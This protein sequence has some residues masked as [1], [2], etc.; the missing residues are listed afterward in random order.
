ME[1]YHQPVLLEESVEGLNLQ[2]EGIYVDATFGGGGHARLILE[3]M[4]NSMLYAFDQDPDAAENAKGLNL[5]LVQA[6]F[7]YLKRYL[8]LYAVPA[9]DG[10]LADLGISSHQIDDAERGFSTRYDTALDMR[11]GQQGA[12]TAATILN[13]YSEPDL[14]QLLSRYGEVRNARTLAQAIGAARVNEPIK[15]AYEL[16]AILAR[17]APRGKENKYYAQVFQALRIAV[18]DEMGAL[19]DLLQQTAELLK[20]GGRMVVISYHSLED[21]MVKQFFAHGNFSG[22]AEKDFYGNSLATMRP[23]NRKP[24]TPSVT[25]IARNSRARSAKLRIGEKL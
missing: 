14:Q 16:K 12:L 3:K 21:R 5:T 6:N 8:R 23:V 9:I 7:R 15:T 4:Q 19:E 17:H 24:I 25:E 1:P 2:P 18:N 22:E 11:M 13:T 20:P 10:L